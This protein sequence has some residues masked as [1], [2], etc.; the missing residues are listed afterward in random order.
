[1][2]SNSRSGPFGLVFN[3]W[4]IRLAVT[5]LTWAITSR[6]VGAEVAEILPLAVPTNQNQRFVL[7]PQLPPPP[8]GVVDF[9]LTELLIASR[10]GSGVDYSPR[11]KELDGKMVRINGY[12]VRQASPIPWAILFSPVP[13]SAHEREYFLCDDLP[14][15]TIHVFFPKSAQPIVPFHPEMVAIIGRL[16]LGGRS[17]ADERTSLARLFVKPGQKEPMVSV[18]HLVRT[19]IT[20]SPMSDAKT[21]PPPATNAAPHNALLKP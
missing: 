13:Q 9:S 6:A 4:I 8:E 11:A 17:E 21:S 7:R 5:V 1:M 12:M 18:S 19:P 15:S 2:F 14:I 3:Q 20:E 10:T 16:E